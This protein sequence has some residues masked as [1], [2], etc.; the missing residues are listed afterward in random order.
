[1][2]YFL[3]PLATAALAIVA[4]LPASARNNLVKNGSFEQPVV[5]DGSY[6]TF[7]AGDSFPGWTVVGAPGNVAIVS[8]DFSYCVPLPAAKGK[9]WLDLTGVSNT[10]TG[11]QTSVKTTPGVV[12]AVTF[13]V[14]NTVGSG[15]C[16]TTSTVDLVIDGQSV[17]SFTNKRTG[18]QEVWR[19]FS[20]DFTAH[21]ATTTIAF[22]NGDSSD[23]TNNGLDAVSV[24]PVH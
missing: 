24:T 1:M 11:V 19:R 8:G 13:F 12:Y 3:R 17:A 10:A 5:G 23:D 6:Q 14:G 9:Q 18:N 16:G 7:N 22:I 15:N 20:T 21:N 2:R 4:A